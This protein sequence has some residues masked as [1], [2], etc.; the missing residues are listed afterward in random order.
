MTPMLLRRLVGWSSLVS[1]ADAAVNAQDFNLFDGM[2]GHSKDDF[3]MLYNPIPYYD[4]RHPKEFEHLKR[5][6]RTVPEVIKICGRHPLINCSKWF[7]TLTYDCLHNIYDEYMWCDW[8]PIVDRWFYYWFCGFSL[9]L[10]Y[11]NYWLRQH[12]DQWYPD[13]Y[14]DPMINDLH[15]D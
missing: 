14:P 13:Q 8:E 15:Y 12:G 5:G 9:W 11:V 6:Y 1:L 3:E 4:G 7:S 2:G 10:C